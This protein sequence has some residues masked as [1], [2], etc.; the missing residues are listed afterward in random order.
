MEIVIT[1]ASYSNVTRRIIN[2]ARTTETKFIRR[3]IEGGVVC[4]SSVSSGEE[5]AC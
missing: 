4:V 2:I 5:S 3:Q 1:N